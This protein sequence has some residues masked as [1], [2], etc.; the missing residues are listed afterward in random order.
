MFR[1]KQEPVLEN[2]FKPNQEAAFQREQQRIMQNASTMLQQKEKVKRKREQERVD[3]IM[4][5]KQAKIEAPV[6][7]A[8]RQA[9]SSLHDNNAG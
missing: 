5:Q 4:R 7:T 1:K 8:D 2:K 6:E 3:S 9:S